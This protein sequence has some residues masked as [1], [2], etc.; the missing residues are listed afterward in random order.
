MVG[1]NFPFRNIPVGAVALALVLALTACGGGGKHGSTP[2]TTSAHKVVEI[3]TSMLKIG[4]VDVESAGPSSPIPANVARTVLTNAQGYLDAALF[5]PLKDGRVGKGFASKFDP[6]LKA[7]V[8]QDK[9]TLTN[10]NVGKFT[11]LKTTATPVL[12]SALDGTLGELMYVAT[13]FDVTEK[14]KTATGNAAMTHHVELTFAPFGSRWLVT[15]YRVQAI[16]SMPTGR[17]KT[18]AK[19][20]A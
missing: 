16:R 7:A 9:G 17:T 10:V 3:K 8:A 5:E 1:V 11:D 19:A 4:G 15:A 12:M 6:G 13:N 2:P 14:G 20:G 18:T